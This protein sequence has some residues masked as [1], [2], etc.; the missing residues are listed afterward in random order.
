VRVN[1][2]HCGKNAGFRKR[3]LKSLFVFKKDEVAAGFR[4]LRNKEL[5]GLYPT[6]YFTWFIISR[7]LEQARHLATYLLTYSMEQT[8]S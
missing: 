1:L 2:S 8:P 3:E 4:N 6:Q 5:N 7:I